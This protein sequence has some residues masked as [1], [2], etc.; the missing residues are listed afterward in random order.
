MPSEQLDLNQMTGLSLRLRVLLAGALLLVAAVS[1]ARPSGAELDLQAEQR[2]QLALEARPRATTAR[3]STTCGRPPSKAMPRR[4]R[5][6][7]WC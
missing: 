3:C 6:S 7:A 2:F 5:C 4:R 1:A